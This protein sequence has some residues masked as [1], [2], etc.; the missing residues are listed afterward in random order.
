MKS[1]APCS[2]NVPL[3]WQ[4][5]TTAPATPAGTGFMSFMVSQVVTLKPVV[6]YEVGPD[7][8]RGCFP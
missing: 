5:S 6:V 4:I 3:T 7:R 8:C 2:T 1:T